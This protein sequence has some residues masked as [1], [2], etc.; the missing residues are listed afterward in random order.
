MIINGYEFACHERWIGWRDQRACQRRN[1]SARFGMFIH[2]QCPQI[3][4][5]QGLSAKFRS[6]RV[7]GGF[8]CW[9]QDFRCQHLE[10]VHLCRQTTTPPFCHCLFTQEKTHS[11]VTRYSAK[12]QT[13][14]LIPSHLVS[15]QIFIPIFFSFC[16]CTVHFDIYKVHTPKN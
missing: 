12:T 7:L 9:C 1:R 15:L 14:Q 4:N 16:R 5:R 6:R 13:H 3:T 2:L 10:S 11:T 8:Y